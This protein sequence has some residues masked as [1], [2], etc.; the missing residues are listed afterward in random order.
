[1]TYNSW[2]MTQQTVYDLGHVFMIWISQWQ[3]PSPPPLS[4][5]V[6]VPT[7]VLHKGGFQTVRSKC[8]CHSGHQPI[9]SGWSCTQ[10]PPH[11]PFPLT[12]HAVAITR[13]Q[14]ET[15]LALAWLIP[16]ACLYQL[17]PND[18]SL[19]YFLQAHHVICPSNTNNL[20]SP[21]AVESQ[22]SQVV[23]LLGVCHM[24]WWD[25]AFRLWSA[26]GACWEEG[27]IIPGIS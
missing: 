25:N 2:S 13:L 15:E 12:A 9:L 1:M 4:L 10:H 17:V 6:C 22:E 8:F 7:C 21:Q 11:M 23:M 20:S 24:L 16:R 19:S 26:G 27:S 5:S 14:P 3:Y 18:C